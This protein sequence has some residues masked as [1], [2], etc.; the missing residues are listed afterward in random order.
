[1]IRKIGL[2]QLRRCLIQ[3]TILNELVLIEQDFTMTG[4]EVSLCVGDWSF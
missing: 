2:R 3:L 1:M 4:E